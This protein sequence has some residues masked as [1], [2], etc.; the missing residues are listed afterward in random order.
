MA[1]VTYTYNL[2]GL[3]LKSHVDLLCKKLT[4]SIYFNNPNTNNN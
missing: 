4:A 1:K 2:D 3:S